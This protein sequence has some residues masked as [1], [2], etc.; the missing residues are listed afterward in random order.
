[1]TQQ[2][3][4]SQDVTQPR[5]LSEHVTQPGNIKNLVVLVCVPPLHKGA[6]AFLCSFRSRGVFPKA[7]SSCEWQRRPFYIA[8]RLR[9]RR[10]DGTRVDMWI[11]KWKSGALPWRPGEHKHLLS[12]R[13]RT[14]VQKGDFCSG[15]LGAVSH[16]TRCVLRRCWSQRAMRRAH[17]ERVDKCSACS[18]EWRRV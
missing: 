15:S 14:R 16:W 8:C 12:R 6:A 2:R 7:E 5:D 17:A 13:F 1:M 3:G 11:W 10:L 18:G 4:I 9:K